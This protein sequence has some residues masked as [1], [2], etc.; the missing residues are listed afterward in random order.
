MAAEGRSARSHI[1][2]MGCDGHTVLCC[3]GRM[4]CGTCMHMY[5]GIVRSDSSRCSRLRL[6]WLFLGDRC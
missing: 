3:V 6:S 4:G 1:W 5:Y 2:F